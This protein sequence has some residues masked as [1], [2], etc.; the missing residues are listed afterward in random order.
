MTLTYSEI[1]STLFL[2][3]A[4][5]GVWLDARLRINTTE[6]DIKNLKDNLKIHYA[7]NDKDNIKLLKEIEQI[8]ENNKQI[9]TQ[10]YDLKILII[11]TINNQKGTS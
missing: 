5:V 6:A 4:I 9:S 7:D 8:N 11:K 10:I 2:L 1:V 3:A